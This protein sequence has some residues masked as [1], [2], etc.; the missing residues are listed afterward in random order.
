MKKRIIISLVAL[1]MP[2]GLFAQKVALKTNLPHLATVTPNLALEIGLGSR[3]TLDLYGAFNNFDLMK[4]NTKWHHWLAQP[5]LRFWTCEKFDGFF[6][7]V[8]AMGGQFNIGGLK[9]PPLA[10]TWEGNMITSLPN[11]R[12]QGWY[13]G[14]GISVGYQW[15]LSNRWNLEASIGGGYNHLWYEKFSKEKCGPKC[16]EGQTN[17]LG[18]TKATLSLVYLFD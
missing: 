10:Y 16:G 8:H 14:G 7:G 6:F 15:V 18:I 5:E 1:L 4:D 9:L 3:T 2:C 17:Y 13:L 11:Y 12:Y